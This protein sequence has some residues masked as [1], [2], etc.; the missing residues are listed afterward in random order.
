MQLGLPFGRLRP[1]AVTPPST[2]AD[3]ERLPRT[4]PATPGRVDVVTIDG[5]AVP[6]VFVR[7][8]R[9]KHY[10]LRVQP[11][12]GLRVT[13]P[14]HGSRAEAARFIDER[15][16][17]IVRERAGRAAGPAKPA[18]WT[19]GTPV[20]FRGDAYPLRTVLLD[21]HRVR[22]SFADQTFVLS[23]ERALRLKPEVE[24]WLR[25]LAS[26]D[27]PERLAWLARQHGFEVKAVSIRNQRS[28][29]GSC[30]PSGRI[31]L[32]WR[33]IQFPPAVADYVLLHELV[34]LRHMNHSRRFWTEVAGLCPTYSV[35]RAWLRAH[36]GVTV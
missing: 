34:H 35:S 12:G 7:T 4:G 31:S 23:A 1:P 26:I 36:G 11:D 19:D 25:R 13:V 10:I 5:H 21:R 8:R 24:A 28:R 18:H 32:N 27:L 17:W 20:L 2:R 3:P 14:W 22:V 33:L 9:A 29:W 30:S 15:R 6:V 16:A